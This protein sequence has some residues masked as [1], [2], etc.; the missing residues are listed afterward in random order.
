MGI[1]LKQNAGKSNAVASACPDFWFSSYYQPC[2]MS[3]YG[4]CSNGVTP[5]NEDGSNCED[6]VLCDGS[7]HGCCPDGFTLKTSTDG[8]NCPA[9]GSALCYNVKSLP[10]EPVNGDC[11]I[12]DPADFKAKFGNSTLCAQQTWAKRCGVTWDGVTNVDN[13]C[14]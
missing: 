13:D 3:E 8:A 6:A 12:K 9:P 2:G 5:A 7:P 1:A 14:R 4:C 10:K 11:K